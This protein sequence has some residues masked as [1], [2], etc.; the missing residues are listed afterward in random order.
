MSTATSLRRLL[1]VTTTAGALALGVAS[2]APAGAAPPDPCTVVTADDIT[3]AYGLGFAPGTPSS[4]GC[5][6]ELADR[7]KLDAF[8]YVDTSLSKTV[9]AAKARMKSFRTS[10]T[11][12]STVKGVGDQAVYA[13]IAGDVLYVRVGKVI[14]TLQVEILDNSGVARKQEIITLGK[15]AAATL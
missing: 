2:A 4:R 12:A 7:S 10:V 9:K 1:V 3:A 11:N 5:D 15:A 6:F 8:A 13:V 14:A